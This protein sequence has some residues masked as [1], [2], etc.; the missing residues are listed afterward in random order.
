EISSLILEVQEK[1]K[2][3]SMIITHDLKCALKVADRI[4]MLNEGK[5]HLLGTPKE[6]EES[7]DELVA[8][9]FN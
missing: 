1:Y 2:T 8:S 7:K 4:L 5:V 9:F 6:F 3:S